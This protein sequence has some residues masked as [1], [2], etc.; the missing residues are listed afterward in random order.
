V[1]NLLVEEDTLGA[2][3]ALAGDDT[4]DEGTDWV[5]S[6]GHVSIAIR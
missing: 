3:P 6:W 5:C 4:I 2:V 1:T